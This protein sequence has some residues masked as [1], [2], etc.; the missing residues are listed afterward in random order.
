MQS[1]FDLHQD[2][3]DSIVYTA[4]TNF[5][6]RS[7][8]H[9]G[10]NHLNIPVNNQ[11]DYERLSEGGVRV[12]GGA[13]CA[14][15]T[16]EKGEITP[17]RDHWGE[18]Q[19]QIELYHEIQQTK[20]DEIQIVETTNDL[21]AADEYRLNI[22]LTI[23]GADSLADDPGRLTRWF[24]QGVR[25]IG[26]TWS[27]TNGIAGGCDEAGDLRE[28]GRHIIGE[29][30]RLGILLDLA[31]INEESFWSA[32]ETSSKPV[33]VSH[34][35]CSGVHE[36]P[37]NLSDEQVRAIGETGGVVGIAGVP[38][39]VGGQNVDSV[40]EHIDHAIQ[41][42]GTEHV[43]IGSDFGSMTA[44]RLLDDFYDVTCFPYL[45]DRLS[46]RGYGQDVIEKVTK[47]NAERVFRTTLPASV[48]R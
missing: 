17:C 7:G 21:N 12:I 33:I 26:L 36:H 6:D 8:L 37:R 25:S 19:K 10:W 38:K 45:V 42:A 32:L 15:D 46:A 39:F 1:I 11:S 41:Y 4:H 9:D 30:E 2:I 44:P 5:F 27:Y 28:A 18:I 40:I 13:S 34:A 23:E 16:N 31:H 35:A 3:S 48:S 43:A 29:M 14:I 24:E 22:I 47:Q 20:S